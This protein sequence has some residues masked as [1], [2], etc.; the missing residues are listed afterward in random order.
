MLAQ[1]YAAAVACGK[2]LYVIVLADLLFKKAL[3][4]EDHCAPLLDVCLICEQDE[5]GN[6]G[7][8]DQ[9]KASLQAVCLSLHKGNR[10]TLESV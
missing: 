7:R 9:Q 10:Q 5:V 6:R 4:S 1:H 8:F 2:H 3:H